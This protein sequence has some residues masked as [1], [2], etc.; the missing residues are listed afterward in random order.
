MFFNVVDWRQGGLI[1]LVG[2]GA[3][4]ALHRTLIP[5]PSTG[6]DP[7]LK[8]FTQGGLSEARDVPREG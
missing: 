8:D 4:L 2:I 7:F 3:H 1:A 6:L 5:A